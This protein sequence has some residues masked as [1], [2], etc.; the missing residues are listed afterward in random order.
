M[1][2]EAAF[3]TGDVLRVDGGFCIGGVIPG[4]DMPARDEEEG[5]RN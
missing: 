1:S 2:D 4:H 3:L 5:L